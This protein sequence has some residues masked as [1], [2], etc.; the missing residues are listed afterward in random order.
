MLI[1][2]LLKLYNQQKRSRLR[3][4]VEK[5]NRREPRL[6]PQTSKLFKRFAVLANHSSLH[7]LDWQRFYEFVRLSRGEAS[8][9][10]LAAL[11]V[12][13]GFSRSKAEYVADIYGHLWAFKRLG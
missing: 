4:R 7:P 2:P 13:E 3:L 11:L 8:E 10:T 1:G 6:P 5:A 12:K 9:P